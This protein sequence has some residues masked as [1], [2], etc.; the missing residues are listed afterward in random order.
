MFDFLQQPVRFE[1]FGFDPVATPDWFPLPIRWYAL[2][3]IVGLFAAWW[4]ARRIVR[5]EPAW[6]QRMRPKPDEFDDLIVWCAFGV[7]LGG[8]LAHILF[9]DF[10]R[11]AADPLSILR[12]WEGGMSFHGG[13][14]GA[15]LAMVLFARRR[16]LPVLSLFDIAGIVA[17]IGLFLG[18]LANFHTGELFGRATDGSWGIIFP[19]GGEAPRH[20]SQLYEAAGEGLILFVLM[21]ILWK[22]GA[23]RRPGLVAGLFAAGYGLARSLAEFAREPDAQLGFL[24]GGWLTMGMA[25]SLPM[26]VAG[27]ALAG[28]SLARRPA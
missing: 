20:P 25:L 4:L 1:R 9:Y 19:R 12:L 15:V 28:R 3:Y 2:A 14:L 10:A 23:L 6:G 27:L 13:F 17:P 24:T 5:D 11:Y 26:L 7:I 8:R 18:R 22:T 21:V 16:G